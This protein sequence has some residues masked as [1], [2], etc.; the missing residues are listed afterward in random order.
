MKARR[1]GAAEWEVRSQAA[2][3][4]L[5]ERG[6]MTRST[7]VRTTRQCFTA[8]ILRSGLLRVDDPHSVT[9]EVASGLTTHEARAF[10]LIELVIAASLASL[11]LVAGYMCLSSATATQKLIEPRAEVIQNARVA[12]NI[13][14]ADL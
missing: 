10:T 6:S 14:S 11:I 2:S 4:A 3:P 13:L 9:R 1:V 8:P 7:L 12:M 5:T